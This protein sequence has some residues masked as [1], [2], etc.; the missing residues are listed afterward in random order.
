NLPSWLDQELTFFLLGRDTSTNEGDFQQS[1]FI[2]G[3]KTIINQFASS[4]LGRWTEERV[5][6]FRIRLV[7]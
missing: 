4:D 2:N 7:R 1:I 5:F 3:Q 6:A